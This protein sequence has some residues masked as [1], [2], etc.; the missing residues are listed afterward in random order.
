MPM[1]SIIRRLFSDLLLHE[2]PRARPVQLA[3]ILRRPDEASVLVAVRICVVVDRGSRDDLMRALVYRRPAV[4]SPDAVDH[5]LTLGAFRRES[6]RAQRRRREA[7]FRN[8]TKRADRE[9]LS[10]M[11]QLGSLA[12]SGQLA[13]V[14]RLNARWPSVSTGKRWLA[15]CESPSSPRTKK[16][17]TTIA[18][19]SAAAIA[20]IVARVEDPA[21]MRSSTTA[22][23]SPRMRRRCSAG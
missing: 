20:A 17:P 2:R 6:N 13:G 5:R 23:R 10:R 19:A 21:L 14:Q 9:R 15:K 8:A 1:A 16:V 3:V 22:T 18:E 4:A 12:D 11:R 7:D